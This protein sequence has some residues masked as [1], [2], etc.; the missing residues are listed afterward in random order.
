M[1]TIITL[2]NA[3]SSE[4]MVISRESIVEDMVNQA[5]ITKGS[6]Q[7][8]SDDTSGNLGFK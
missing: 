2:K 4:L 6:I 1:G 8:S 3:Y 7:S 5:D